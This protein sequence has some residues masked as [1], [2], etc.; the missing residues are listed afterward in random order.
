MPADAS[1]F[2]FGTTLVAKSVIISSNLCL[3]TALPAKVEAEVL[4]PIILDVPFNDSLSKPAEPL[5]SPLNIKSSP[6][7]D[8]ADEFNALYNSS[9]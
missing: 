6:D 8:D 7:S 3:V 5:P 9:A 4:L 2:Q 1:I